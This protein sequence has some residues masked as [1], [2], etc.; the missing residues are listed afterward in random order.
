MKRI[1]PL[2]NVPNEFFGI[3]SVANLTG[4]FNIGQWA[5]DVMVC[6]FN[7]TLTAIWHMTI[8]A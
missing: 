6:I 5:L 8:G 4:I 1:L 2:V 3:L 7:S